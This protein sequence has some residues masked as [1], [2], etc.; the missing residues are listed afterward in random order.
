MKSPITKGRLAIDAFIGWLDTQK[1]FAAA[2]QAAF[3][4]DLYQLEDWLTARNQ[5]LAGAGDLELSDLQAFAGSLF[6]AGLAKSSIARKLATARCFFRY[7]LRQ[8]KIES[9]P[10]RN[11][12]NPKQEK[13]Q[14][15]MLNVDEAFAMLDCVPGNGTE[16]TAARGKALAELL[17]GS[18]LRISEALALD[19]K[20]IDSAHAAVRVLGKGARE[21]VCPLSETCQD[22]LSIWLAARPGIAN[23]SESALFVGNRGKRL[24]RR[25]AGRIIAN[26]C[27]GAGLNKTVSPHGLRHSFA[28]HLLAAGADMRSVQ[29][30]LGHSRLATTQR[31]THLGLEKIISIYD[32]AHPRSG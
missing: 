14:P 28:S 11:L 8:G 9:D 24:N 7:L 1:G 30:L 2:T 26:L 25:Q 12:H 29:E 3:R 20:D 17:Y 23:P 21:R 6:R 4:S 27:A 15:R 31:Y 22:A 10:A 16:A 32:S 19:V 18:G 5:T 13:I